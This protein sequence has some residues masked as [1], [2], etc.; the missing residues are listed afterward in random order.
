MASNS[1]LKNKR[2]VLEEPT[3][4]QGMWIFAD[5]ECKDD[6]KVM[7]APAIFVTMVGPFNSF[8]PQS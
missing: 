3:K 5:I 4:E 6:K 1:M 2:K 8:E 7:L